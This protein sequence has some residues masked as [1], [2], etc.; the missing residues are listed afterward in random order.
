MLSSLAIFFSNTREVM[1]WVTGTRTFI[2][3]N[4]HAIFYVQ[5]IFMQV[6]AKILI[7]QT[8]D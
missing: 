6:I 5:A 2:V 1:I 4:S 7:E 3:D 8:Y